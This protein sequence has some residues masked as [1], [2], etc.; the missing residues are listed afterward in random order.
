MGRPG[1]GSFLARWPRDPRSGVG[2]ARDGS[3]VI[4]GPSMA[5]T[6]W[7]PLLLIA[8]LAACANPPARE[9]PAAPAPGQPESAPSQPSRV[10]R[11]VIRAEPGSLSGVRLIPTGITT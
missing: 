5:M 8:L 4:R 6:R 7:L 9:Q 10:L 2:T 11:A 3:R 1:E